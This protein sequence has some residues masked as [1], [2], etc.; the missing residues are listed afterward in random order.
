MTKNRAKFT[1]FAIILVLDFKLRAELDTG[2]YC[3]LSSSKQL[4]PEPKYQLLEHE[5]CLP[6]LISPLSVEILK[7]HS[8]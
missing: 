4:L 5:V 7:L 8:G 2:R 1:I 6:N 3:R